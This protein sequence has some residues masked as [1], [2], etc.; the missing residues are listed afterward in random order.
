MAAAVYAVPDP[1]SAD[2]VMAAVEFRAGTS[3]E[4]FRRGLGGFLSAQADLGTKWAPRFVR[5]VSA[6]PLTATGKITKSTIKNE[7]WSCAD[8]VIWRPDRAGQEYRLFDA[9]DVAALE[10]EFATHGRSALILGT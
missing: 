10:S 5:I 1:K 9:D 4:E 7:R 2:Q 6:L 3:A 8:E